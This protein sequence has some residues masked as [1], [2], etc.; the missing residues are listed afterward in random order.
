MKFEHIKNQG[1][2]GHIDDGGECGETEPFA[3]EFWDTSDQDFGDFGDDSA[4]DK[5]GT[6]DKCEA[7]LVFEI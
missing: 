3:V 2:E 6:E 7:R 5:T 1:G 4:G